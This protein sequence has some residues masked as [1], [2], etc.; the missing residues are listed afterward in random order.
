M[1]NVARWLRAGLL[2]LAACAPCA[3]V[4]SGP[5]ASQTAVAPTHERD[6]QH[7]FDF[8]LGSWNIHL[9]RRLHPLTGSEAWV[10]FDGTSVTRK[11]WDGRADLE[12]FET[13]GAAGRIQGLT[14]RLY[15]PQTHQ[16]SLYWANAKDGIV[17]A[18]Q[19]GQFADGTG[20]FFGQDSFDGRPVLIRFVWSRTSTAS[21]HFEQ[22]F[23]ADGGRS[24]E[25]NW[26]T[27]QTRMTD[28][29]AATQRRHHPGDARSSASA[30]DGQ[31][32]FDPL[33][34]DWKY[35]LKRRLHPLTGSNAWAEFDGSGSCAPVWDGRAELEQAE[36]DGPSGHIQ[37]LTLRL[38]DPQ[39]HQWRLY[40]AN[41]KDGVLEAPQIGQFRGGHGEFYAQDSFD[42]KSIFVRFD[43]TNMTG[44]TPH[45]EQS[46]SADGG[47]TWEVNWITQ[48][49]RVGAQ[50]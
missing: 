32:D 1:P 23:S 5:P 45:F 10:E 15:N 16:W 20:E 35:H 39:S 27:D 50:P 13:A 47:K 12:E 41:S 3:A 6:G 36:F 17:V 2:T 7:D 21:P 46:F 4:R 48:Q 49:R 38:F 29:A 22:S 24:W 30:A 34:G 44:G 19:V 37:G 42:G 25:V 40:W 26:I 11:V 14:L 8:E 31:R 9:K 18:P 33:L 43:W 28:A